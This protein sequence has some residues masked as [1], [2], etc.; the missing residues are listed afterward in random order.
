M[1]YVIIGGGPTGLTLAYILGKL[2]KK[3]L[4]I[5][6]NS[7]LGGFHRSNYKDGKYYENVP[8]VYSS[9][10]NNTKMIMNDMNIKFNDVFDPCN[11]V[12]SDIKQ[13]ND[14]AHN[15]ISCFIFEYIKLI[16]GVNDSKH[17][18]VKQ[19]MINHKFTN[20]SMEY[21][22]RLCR[23]TD[24]TSSDKFILFELLQI[25]NIRPLHGIFKSKNKLIDIWHQ[26]ILDT[27]HVTVLLNTTVVKINNN[28]IILHD[29]H[30]IKFNKLLL[31]LPPAPLYHLAKNI[32]N[33]PKQWMINNSY[34]D[35]IPI[36]F[37]VGIPIPKFQ[38]SF[39]KSDWGIGF[40]I[41]SDTIVSTCASLLDVKSNY[42]NK[43]ANE[44]TKEEV[45]KEIFRQLQLS[46]YTLT[47]YT[48]A[49]VSAE[50][51]NNKWI[52]KDTAFIPHNYDSFI[53][54][55]SATHPNIFN[56]GT[57]NGYGYDSYPFTTFESAVTN[58][59][60]VLHLIEPQSRIYKIQNRPCTVTN[61]M[62]ILLVI[63][64]IWLIM[65]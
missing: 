4:L 13:T 36:T 21:F 57:H 50:K 18:S 15:E 39:I 51:I 32:F 53:S 30:E 19:F 20:D 65:K 33:I 56:V 22:D 3:C 28:S 25:Y 31:A 16:F 23:L 64:G 63:F 62:R 44:S 8:H 61:I 5:D 40:L 7:S 55:Y 41:L 59:L 54:C 46:I 37:H 27:K 1:D 45:I 49:I 26:K 35:Y 14:L 48:D 6:K 60:Y 34:I 43:T 52:N 17:I 29:N 12:I 47:H 38:Y 24:G 9:A 11:V 42:T 58:A 2:K 10:Y